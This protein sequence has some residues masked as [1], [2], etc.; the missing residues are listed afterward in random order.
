MQSNW[1]F[2]SKQIRWNKPVMLSTMFTIQSSVYSVKVWTVS[3]FMQ[4]ILWT[5]DL[6]R[7]THQLHACVSNQPAPLARVQGCVLTISPTTNVPDGRGFI[8]HMQIWN[9]MGGQPR[10]IT[11]IRNRCIYNESAWQQTEKQGIV[12]PKM[13]ILLSCT[14]M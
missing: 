11:P 3:I 12:H 7:H 5:P 9:L 6:D 8:F 14:I 13:K 2:L 1:A 4:H 10:P